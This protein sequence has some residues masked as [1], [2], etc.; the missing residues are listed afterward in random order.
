MT[1]R[2]RDMVCAVSNKDC[3]SWYN[4]QHYVVLCEWSC[5][6][7]CNASSGHDHT[8]SLKHAQ[9]EAITQVL[10]S[11]ELKTYITARME[12]AS[13]LIVIIQFYTSSLRKFLSPKLPNV[14]NAGDEVQHW[15]WLL[16][17]FS[18]RCCVTHLNARLLYLV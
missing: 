8:M 15:V 3:M 6:C 17:T 9:C 12:L 16:R 5:G 7:A 10:R 13:C 18:D 14:L 2:I 4:L 1:E 11:P